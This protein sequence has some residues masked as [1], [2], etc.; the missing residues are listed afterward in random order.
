LRPSAEPVVDEILLA[1]AK[2]QAKRYPWTAIES[3]ARFLTWRAYLHRN[4]NRLFDPGPHVGAEPRH[5]EAM[6]DNWLGKAIGCVAILD[7]ESELYPHSFHECVLVGIFLG[8]SYG[9]FGSK[10]FIVGHFSGPGTATHRSPLNV[11]FVHVLDEPFQ[12]LVDINYRDEDED[13]FEC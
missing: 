8:I 7:P 11:G 2:R 10:D 6:N 13:Y 9:Y 5:W 4:D 12:K 3:E 1:R